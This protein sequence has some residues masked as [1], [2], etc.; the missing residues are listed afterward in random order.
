ML[1]TKYRAIWGKIKRG[2]GE[3]ALFFTVIV[4]IYAYMSET[5]GRDNIQ[6]F[7]YE[8][9]CKNKEK[10]TLKLLKEIGIGE[11]YLQA[12]LSALE[13]DSQ[14]NSD[15]LSRKSL[16]HLKTLAIFEDMMEWA[17]KVAWDQFGIKLEGVEGRAEN[18]HSP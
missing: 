17:K 3:E 18:L 10:F 8:E 7:T 12:A 13:K 5:R 11:E 1:P 2:S 15:N 9:L 14:A 4:Q 6:S 16:S